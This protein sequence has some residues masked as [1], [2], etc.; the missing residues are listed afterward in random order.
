[1]S[2]PPT[3]EPSSLRVGLEVVGLTGVAILVSILGGVAF[4]VPV[5]VLGFDLQ[6]TFVLLGSTAAGQLGLLVVAAAY[7]RHRGMQI[8]V[9]IPSRT[10]VWQIVGWTTFTL[11]VAI[12]VS[13]VLEFLDLVP[14]SI[15]AELALS[16]PT[17]LL[18]LA[19]LSVVLVAP[20]EELLFRGAIQGRLRER[21]GPA[22][23]IIGSSLLFGSVHFA[24]FTGSL[25]P[26]LATVAL[27]AG[28]GA[29]FGYAYERSD[30]LLVPIT[31][32][33]TYNVVLLLISFLSL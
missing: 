21:F 15:I 1:M 20:A 30:N 19:V 8:H 32:H 22:G 33:G 5:L 3:P 10:G 14:D 11:V 31:I 23:A 4:V 24:N 18:A 16:D 7:I 28:V 9:S 29:V 6:T 17:F 13:I 25:A 26:I 27:L 2:D 12:L